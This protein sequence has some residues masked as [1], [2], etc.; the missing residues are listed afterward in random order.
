ML[1]YL[2]C[3][4]H[5]LCFRCY[6]GRGMYF[7]PVSLGGTLSLE[8]LVTLGSR[9]RSLMM[10]VASRRT[11][12][13]VTAIRLSLLV[14]SPL[15]AGRFGSSLALRTSGASPV[16]LCRPTRPVLSSI[17]GE[18]VCL[19]IVGVAPKSVLLWALSSM[20]SRFLTAEPDLFFARV[21]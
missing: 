11:S 10:C 15:R 6:P 16:L 4:R 8:E 19:W 3:L 14:L 2:F 20:E 1:G 12:R 7:D 5:L 9:G 17:A 18:L 13:F 21:S